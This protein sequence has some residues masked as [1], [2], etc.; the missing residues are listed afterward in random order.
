MP[1]EFTQYPSEPGTQKSASRGFGPAG[2]RMGTD[3]LDPPESV[4]PS[5]LMKKRRSVFF[6]I[7]AALLLGAVAAVIVITLIGD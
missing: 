3:L 2:E 5:G 6:W 4:P 1:H 7:G